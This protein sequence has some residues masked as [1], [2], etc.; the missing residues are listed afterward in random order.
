MDWAG[1][2]GEQDGMGISAGRTETPDDVQQCPRQV[3]G[4]GGHQWGLVPR[5]WG[6][7]RM[8]GTTGLRA[9]SKGEGTGK[10]ILP[11]L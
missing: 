2:V 1:T 4:W 9:A 11:T 6:C 7:G 3:P 8:S 10:A 5:S